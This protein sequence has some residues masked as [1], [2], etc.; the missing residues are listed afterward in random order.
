M[1]HARRTA[2][3]S[4]AAALAFGAPAGR[5]D[6]LIYHFDVNMGDSTLIVD[7]VS[8]RTLLVD[9]GNRG[10]GR[11]VVA[12]AL[13][14]LGH[15][16][17]TYFLATH[18]DSDHIGGFDELIEEGVSIGEAVLDRGDRTDRKRETQS[19]RLS[20]YGEYLQAAEANGRRT[21]EPACDP[22]L[23]LG[24]DIKIEVVAA[25]GKYLQRDCL[26]GDMDVDESE[27]NDLSVALTLKIGD[28]QYFIGGDLT[29]GG[30]GTAEMEPQAAPRIGDVDVLKI[31]H[32]GSETSSNEEF[33]KILSPEVVVISVGDGGVNRRYQ[34]P[35][36]SVLD[37][38]ADSPGSP[39]VFL[40]HRGEGGLYPGGHIEN[41]HIVIHTNG[42]G[43]LVNGVLKP[44]DERGTDPTN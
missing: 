39:E 36:Q 11:K 22:D 7:T 35:R 2:A 5:A 12:P 1:R 34:L 9:A 26:Q 38:L 40:T 24:A 14:A 32:H 28:F 41:R 3:L 16:T 18:Y 37:R 19:G 25:A 4:F 8:G 30:N 29:G 6:L 44:V 33:L 20:Q 42:D 13:K 21:L 10:Y 15:G 23:D 17:V 27:D 43:Y 31:N